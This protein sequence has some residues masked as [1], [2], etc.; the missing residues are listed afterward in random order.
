MKRHLIYCLA[1]VVGL[2]SCNDFL[3]REPLDF[4]NE[5]TY[6]RTANDLKIAANEFYTFLPL[7]RPNNTGLYADDNISDN[8]CKTGTPSELLYLGN[9]RTVKIEDSEWD[10]GN[11]R[12]INFFINKINDNRANISGNDALINHYLGEG[13]FFRAWEYFR[14][15][16]QFGDV[17]LI[18]TTMPDNPAILTQNSVR[19]PRNE[20]ARFIIG[21]LD[22]AADGM[23]LETAPEAGRVTRDAALML[24]A[25]VAL[26]EGTWE[27][28]HAGTCFVPGNS[29]WPGAG[30]WPGFQFT[31]GSAEKEIEW[32][33][34][35]A[36]SAADE[37]ASRRQLDQDYA[38]MF[39]QFDNEFPANGEVILARYYKIGSLSHNCSYFLKGGG[40][41]GVTRSLV[42]SFVM[43]NG[44]PIY[45]DGA[46]YNG[47]TYS[48][49]ELQGR[50][51][52]LSESVRGAG[53]FIETRPNPDKPGQ[54]INDT[55]YYH[56][57]N[58]H[59]SGNDQSVTGY[60]IKKWYNDDPVQSAYGSCST[61]VPLLRAGEAYITY[62]EA[63]YERYRNLGGNCDTYWRALRRRAGVD[64][65][66][67][68][69]INATDLDK[70]LAMNPTGF[71]LAL[72]SKGVL[73]DKTLYNIRRERR[74][75]FIAE[76]MRTDDLKRWRSF[77]KMQNYQ[78][79]G[80]NLW[81]ELYKMYSNIDG[82]ES[83]VSSP[84]ESKYLRPLQVSFSS[85]VYNGY[86]FPKPHYLE[87]IPISE[88][89]LTDTGSGSILY[90]N[91]GWPTNAD[92]LADYSYDC[93]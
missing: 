82:F 28:Y 52:R 79:E 77:D 37:I 68:I 69:T 53:R 6:Y 25:R 62:I 57:P 54:Y 86:N 24:K 3:E 41:M 4:G 30:T 93:D 55:I 12:E 64:E 46:Q 18:T 10:F 84:N 19:H 5:N 42:N 89:S 75:E 85:I 74:C 33:L 26:Y 48:Y 27:R 35:Q 20:V 90:Q 45:A 58:I 8:Q 38:A 50:D 78:P 91:P 56:R 15:L 22:K 23:L 92:G 32:F 21:E 59:I 40:G 80:F 43:A 81:D 7:N 87:P 70:E 2:S 83:T 60:E 13:H 34:E 39:N 88:F 1:A 17:P 73:V 31:A 63:Y 9:K 11:L 49:L 29:K 67:M 51:K 71:D 44:L 72:Y 65:D 61:N 16:R 47:D 14:L 36:I 66:Y 76:G